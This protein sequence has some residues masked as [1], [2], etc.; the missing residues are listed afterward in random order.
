MNR[1][2]LEAFARE[3]AKGIK[4]EKDLADFSQTLTKI[5]VEAALNAELATHLGYEKHQPS[6]TGNSR[7]GFSSKRLQTEEGQ[8][9][10]DIPRDRNSDFEPQ[11]VKKSQTRFT[12]MNDK[13]LSLYAKG[14]STRDIVDTFKEMYDA[15]ISPTL[16]SNVTNA[17]IEQIVEWQSRPLDTLYPIV[18]L[19]CIV[20][21]IRQ[22][23]QVINKAIYL[24]LGV[25]MDGHKELLGM[26]LSENEGAKF[27]LNVLTELNNRG[28]KD[29][30]I[31][32]VDGLKGFPDAINAV[33]ADTD[34]QL[35]IV[36]MVRNS[37]KYVS[38]KDYKA[39]TSDLKQIY[40]A[41][42]EEDAL[43]A[44][45]QFSERWDDKYPQISKSW[46][47]HWEN[48]NT[49]FAYPQEIRKAIYTT[50]AIESLNSV[51]RK[52]VKKRK[53]FPSDNAAK[54]VV[55]LAIM[56]ASKKWTMPIQNWK[57]AMNRFIIQFEDRLTDFI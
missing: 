36:H 5:T 4:T 41:T 10:I 18:Y 21:K 49:F 16:I 48:L 50:N 52:A 9:I 23:K 32:C 15:D 53:L 8:F 6:Q 22:D 24:A 7:N 51:I 19:D 28:V 56:A 57:M 3:A 47:S 45:D 27:W 31:A 43:L 44:L 14:M 46:R 1:Q 12:T 29:I 11:L 2:E 38:W 34:I 42:T 37:L 54:K 26:W 17:V 20:V 13:I 25:N 55:Y 39:V 33:F 30:L 40:K 35:C